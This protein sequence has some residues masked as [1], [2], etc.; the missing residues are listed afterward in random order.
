MDLSD[1]TDNYLVTD[2]SKVGSAG[3]ILNNKGNL[4]Y[5]A[6]SLI[7]C[8]TKLEQRCISYVLNKL[9]YMKIKTVLTDYKA[10]LGSTHSCVILNIKEDFPFIPCTLR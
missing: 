6:Q 8:R 10:I 3:L 5:T 9:P 2:A 1:T 7:K 4:V